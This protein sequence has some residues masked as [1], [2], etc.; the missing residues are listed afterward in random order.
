MWRQ[1]LASLATSVGYGLRP[2]KKVTERCLPGSDL[3][4][5]RVKV[6]SLVDS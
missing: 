4:K 3:H 2:C 1:P 5:S 6:S